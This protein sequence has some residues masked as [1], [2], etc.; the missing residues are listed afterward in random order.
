MMNYCKRVGIVCGLIIFVVV[1]VFSVSNAKSTVGKIMKDIPIHPKG[2]V[3]YAATITLNGRIVT[4]VVYNLEIDVD[5]AI[6][7]YRAVLRDK[8]MTWTECVYPLDWLPI[9]GIRVHDFS[10]HDK[11]YSLLFPV[12]EDMLIPSRALVVV[13][14]GYDESIYCPGK[15][16]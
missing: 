11:G 12:M 16:V 5:D 4:G 2:E 8:M 14:V 3:A 7:Y 1:S 13:A 9:D 10:I 15:D 6:E